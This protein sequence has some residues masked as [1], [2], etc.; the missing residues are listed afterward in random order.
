MRNKKL[1]LVS[2]FILA[3][4]VGLF[5]SFTSAVNFKIELGDTTLRAGYMRRNM[6]PIHFKD[7]WNDFGWFIYFSNGIG[8]D[9]NEAETD[10][11][12]TVKLG[13][14][15]YECQQKVKWFYYNAERWERLW[16]LG[17]N[18][19]WVT[20]SGWIYTRCRQEWFRRTMEQMCKNESNES[21]REE[22]EERIREQFVDSHG[23]Y[24]MVRH[25]YAGSEFVLSAWTNYVEKN[26]TKVWNSLAPT[27]IR[28]DN[29]YPV[30]LIYDSNGWVWFL[31]WSIGSD[32]DIND[33][34][35]ELNKPGVNGNIEELFKL[36]T[37][38]NGIS[39]KDWLGISLNTDKW[40]SATNS[41]L[42]V[43]VDGLVWI[44]R[45][46]GT[47]NAGIQWNQS[48]DKMQYFS[49]VNINNMQLINYARQRA[50]ILCRWKWND[51]YNPENPISCVA[52]VAGPIIAEANGKT[53]IVK[54]ANVIVA[55]MSGN[56]DG[57][58]N[59]DIFIDGWNLVVDDSAVSE[60][61]VFKKNWF[62][63]DMTGGEFSGVVFPILNSFDAPAYT[64]QEV[65][66]W[67]YIKWNFIVN[68]NIKSKEGS[69]FEN[70]YFI[71]WKMTTKDTVDQLGKVFKRRCNAWKWT[72][73]TPC[74]GAEKGM[75]GKV[76]WTNPYENASLVIID[77]NYPSPLYQ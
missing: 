26:P 70:V 71:Y 17:E 77:Q 32:D 45:D 25:K 42:S 43:I 35:N 11:G 31:W 15:I 60:L 19:N 75:N 41:L 69:W 7:N 12:Y 64:W 20:V 24:G 27:L 49:S 16:S 9:E 37:E 44:N 50:E 48:N 3:V 56:L 74:P 46:T 47:G 73:G 66:A 22:C 28:F 72:D 8:S 29:K 1:C 23:Y 2:S 4:F 6:T 63:S 54:W 55:P 52:G 10:W 21:E 39:P 61:K 36:N 68:G 5:W 59:Y 33:L 40:W 76:E 67:K 51:R 38:W 13:S 65:V 34:L 18:L 30:W 57:N 53:L 62:I 58:G 14:T